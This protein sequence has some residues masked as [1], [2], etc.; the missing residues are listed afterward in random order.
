MKREASSPPCQK[1][2]AS[3]CALGECRGLPPFYLV[4]SV[5][6]ALSTGV[7]RTLF[8]SADVAQ[9]HKELHPLSFSSSSSS[10]LRSLRQVKTF[11][12]NNNSSTVFRTLF[13]G[14]AP[15]LLGSSL[16]GSCKFCCYE[17]F[18]QLYSEK[19]AS[20]NHD[21]NKEDNCTAH[22][23][24]NNNS[25]EQREE[26][27]YLAAGASAE[28]MAGIL[29]CP[30]RSVAVR[31]QT[32]ASSPSPS[33][34]A[35]TATT[36]TMR[37]TMRTMWKE[38][39]LLGGFFKGLTPLWLREVPTTAMQFW[40]FERSVQML[41]TYVLPRPPLSSFPF[42]LDVMLTE[43]EKRE[44]EQ[45]R[46]RRRLMVSCVAGGMAGGIA[47][48]VTHPTQVILEAMRARHQQR[49]EEKGSKEGREQGGRR[50]RWWW[51]RGLGG[52]M[53]LMGGLGAVQWLLYDVI[54]LSAGLPT[55]GYSSQ[56]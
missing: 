34:S 56:Q 49:I 18:R 28:L 42:A 33:A 50:R 38:E 36:P 16:Y 4:C 12:A 53:A 35:S 27:V 22:K 51:W 7:A 29:W 13:S 15:T 23:H 5:A 11:G 47:A 37:S 14:W 54:K 25:G 24:N 31:M 21:R 10:F 6:G 3:E 32:I 52:R 46:R 9:L 1:T 17:Y 8:I 2:S 43:E 45:R 19:W 41:H 20:D 40:A 30:F 55:I 26:W 39:G 44:E 48:V